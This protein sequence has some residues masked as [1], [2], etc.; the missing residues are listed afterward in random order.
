MDEQQ[1]ERR[2]EEAR[3]I[4][5]DPIY[6]ESWAALRETLTKRLESEL[7]TPEQRLEIVDLLRANR[8]ARLY[9]E[10]VLA[11]GT[12]AAAEQERKRSLRDRL[13]RRA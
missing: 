10:Q 12:M 13:L 6:Q 2:G 1:Q 4:L 8:K 7:L 11:T 3:R 5:N 9:M